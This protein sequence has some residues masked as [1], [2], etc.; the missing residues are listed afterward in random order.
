MKDIVP[1]NKPA[2]LPGLFEYPEH[3]AHNGKRANHAA[4]M[5]LSKSRNLMLMPLGSEG[6]WGLCEVTSPGS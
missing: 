3:Q 1:P 4:G 5:M 6:R 2:H